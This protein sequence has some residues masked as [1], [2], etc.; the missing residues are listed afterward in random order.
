VLENPMNDF[1]EFKTW[2]LSF[3]K[4]NES[5]DICLPSFTYGGLSWT[6]ST[7]RKRIRIISGSGNSIATGAGSSSGARSTSS[8]L[9]E[10]THRP[11]L[12]SAARSSLA[13][14]SELGDYFG[15]AI[16][17]PDA[18][19]NTVP[20]QLL[21]SPMTIDDLV[22]PKQ[23]MIASQSEVLTSEMMAARFPDSSSFDWTRLPMSAAL[24]KHIQFARSIDWASTAL[25]PIENWTFDLRAMCNLIMGSPHPA[26]MYWGDEYIA[27]YNEAYIMLAGQKH[28]HLMVSA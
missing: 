5:L 21:P 15:D 17:T 18:I 19:F 12:I 13:S 16:Q 3:V 8:G 4:N 27:I 1:P 26:A 14:S 24:P 11:T 28:P 7:L 25:G 23:A 6:C 20:E 22:P 9:S 2:T 10:R